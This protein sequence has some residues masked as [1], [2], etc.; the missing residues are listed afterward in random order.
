MGSSEFYEYSPIQAIVC[1]SHPFG[2]DELIAT[3]DGDNVNLNIQKNEE[4]ASLFILYPA[5]AQKLF[6]WLKAKGV[7]R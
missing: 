6:D 5:A 1:I 2:K 7:V 4:D 3:L